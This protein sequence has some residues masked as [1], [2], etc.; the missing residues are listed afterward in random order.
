MWG[1]S[2]AKL[3]LSATSQA[4]GYQMFISLMRTR[5]VVEKYDV[6]FKSFLENQKITSSKTYFE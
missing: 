4:L 6:A 2:E 5:L 3:T 1:P